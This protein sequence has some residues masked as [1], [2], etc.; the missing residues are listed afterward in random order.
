MLIVIICCCVVVGSV[1]HFHI[2][3]KSLT[4]FCHRVSDPLN[5]S[6]IFSSVIVAI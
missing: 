4:T 5:L 2:L 3:V 6:Y 1:P